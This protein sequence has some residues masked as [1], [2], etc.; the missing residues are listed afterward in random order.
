MH[1]FAEYAYHPMWI[2]GGIFFF[3]ILSAFGLPLPE[4]VVLIS[5]GLVGY[6]SLHPEL[7]PPPYPGAPMVNVYVLAAASFVSVVFS[8]Y[9]IFFLGQRYGRRI[10][11]GRFFSRLIN[12]RNMLKIETWVKA[13][14][15]FAC[16]IFRFTPGIRFPG[17]LM[18]GAMGLNTLG[19][20][21]ID[22]AAAVLTAPTQVLLAAFYGN[23]ILHYL[24]Q[25]KIGVLAVITIVIVAMYIRKIRE[26]RS[27]MI[28][29]EHSAL[30]ELV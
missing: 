28:E 9:L 10:L 23:E 18:C 1:F 14:G 15:Y 3:M 7:H 25:F 6:A 8:D 22:S 11:H 4:E 19:Y 5:S 30:K 17:H 13:Y 29:L 12:P 2:Y 26:K 24:K 20:L 21:A 16:V 27:L